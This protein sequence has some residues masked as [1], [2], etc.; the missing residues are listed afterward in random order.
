[1]SDKFNGILKSALVVSPVNDLNEVL[2][3]EIKNGIIAQIGKDLNGENG[4]DM[5]GKIIMPAFVEM[6]CHLREPGYEEKETIESGVASAI[7]GG[8]SAICPMANT[9][10]VNDGVEILKYIKNKQNKIDVLPICAVT[11]GLCGDELVDFKVLKENGAIGFSNDGR[12]LEDMK[13]LKEALAKAAQ[14]DALVISHAEDTTYEP[15]DPKSEYSAVLRELDVVK[16]TDARYHFAHISTK[17]SVELIREAKAEGWNVTCETA[18]HYFTL[19]KENIIDNHAR[20]K[21]NPPLR[22]KDDVQAIIDGLLDGTIDVIATDHAPHT[23]EEKNMSFEKAPMGIV[24]FETAFSLAYKAFIETGYMTLLSLVKKFSLNPS[25][26]LNLV[27][28]G[29]IEAGM[30]A[31][32]AIFDP[33][34]EWTVEAKNFKTKCKITPFEGMKLKGKII[35]TIARGNKYEH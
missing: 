20:F 27:N 11:K 13:E 23:Y 16:E 29:K 5:S 6:H 15:Q 28:H 33:S 18:P 4:I 3:I 7:A 19:S 12:P 35:G 22:E 17:E 21:M 31:N 2:D 30:P 10:P 25:V 14:I 8:Y 1:M 34:Q 32:L 24:G 9:K 26:I